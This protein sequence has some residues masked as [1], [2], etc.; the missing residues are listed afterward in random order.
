MVAPSVVAWPHKVPAS[1]QLIREIKVEAIKQERKR[2]HLL[3]APAP[4]NFSELQINF[5]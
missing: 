5:F 1:L 3:L 2:L 4:Q